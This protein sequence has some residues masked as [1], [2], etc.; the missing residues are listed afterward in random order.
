MSFYAILEHFLI[1]DENLDIIK[2]HLRGINEQIPLIG[3]S[4]YNIYTAFKPII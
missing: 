3:Y 4:L 1:G 2:Y